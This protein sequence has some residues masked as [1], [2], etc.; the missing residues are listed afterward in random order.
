MSEF[1]SQKT[2]LKYRK[3]QYYLNSFEEHI[4]ARTNQKND[5]KTIN[6]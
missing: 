5:Y 4:I 6:E 3:E 1:L 2:V